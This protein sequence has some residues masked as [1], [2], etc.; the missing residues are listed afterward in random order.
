MRTALD[1]IEQ[2]IN[3]LTALMMGGGTVAELKAKKDT[4]APHC[5]P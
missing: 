4:L 1:T 3:D 5:R 2:D